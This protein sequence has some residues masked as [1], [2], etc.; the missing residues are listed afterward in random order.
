MSGMWWNKLVCGNEMMQSMWVALLVRMIRIRGVRVGDSS[1]VVAGDSPAR[2][3][4]DPTV[5]EAMR[6]ALSG[7]GTGL[8]TTTAVQRRKAETHGSGYQ[9]LG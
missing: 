5:A 2:K 9:L 3:M 4:A 7:M 1:V 6:T 8:S